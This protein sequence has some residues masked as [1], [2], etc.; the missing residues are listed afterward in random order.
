MTIQGTWGYGTDQDDEM[1]FFA[2]PALCKECDHN[3]FHIVRIEA[4]AGAKPMA[5]C[6]QCGTLHGICEMGQ[7]E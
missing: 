7:E 6:E 1:Q 2:A 3:L 5:M 4:L